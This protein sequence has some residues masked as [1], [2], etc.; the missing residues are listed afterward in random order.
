MKNSMIKFLHITGAIAI[1]AGTIMKL[2][3]PLYAHYI[4][5]IGAILFST[6]QFI[7][8]PGKS[9]PTI[10]RLVLQ[11]QLGGILL[12]TAGVLMFMDMQEWLI[13]MLIGAVFELYTAYRI[14]QEIE[15]NR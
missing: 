12:I 2:S 10:N 15:K 8:R 1:L 9:T 4:Y 14:P 3:H 6:M 13:T 11:Q 5:I 7:M